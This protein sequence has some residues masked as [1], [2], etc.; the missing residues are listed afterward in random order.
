MKRNTMFL[1]WVGA[2]ISV[3]EIFTGGL[4]A[5]L[6][7]V[8]GSAAILVGHLIGTGLLALGAYV[9][10]VRGVNSM[11]NV[12]FAFGET[13]GRIVAAINLLQLL[14]WIVILI[15]QSGSAI[16]SVFPGI[17]FKVVTFTLSLLQIIWAM[18]FGTPASRINDLAVVLLALLCLLFFGEA[19]AGR[20][21]VAP[22]F[23]ASAMN[24]VLGIELSIAMPVSWLPLVGDYSSKAEDGAT[25]FIMPFLGYFA[26]SCF[27]YF[28][29]F[30]IALTGGRDIFS[31]IAASRF[32]YVA[33]C[34]VL[35]STI[36]T[37]FVALY[38]AAV[39][40]T[41][42]ICLSRF[43]RNILLVG[44]TTLLLAVL[45]PVERFAAILEHFLVSIDTV[46]V[47]IFT[48]VFLDF[49]RQKKAP[50]GKLNVRFVVISLIGM[51][52][53]LFFAKYVPFIPTV[54]TII[55]VALVYLIS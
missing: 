32:R 50:S 47:P 37:N 18:S 7:V 2:A 19:F 5:P 48:L 6:G 12:S 54:S 55:F 28:L 51:L 40:S 46:F 45:F 44:I 9:A 36:T 38:S 3:S 23:P 27:M 21:A 1:L 42:L 15:V 4:L 20:P 13:G 16:T 24:L 26:G 25:A 52:G 29:G 14:G 31:F 34:V 33:C 22:A 49:F 11:E 8:K 17:P 30:T 43:S 10:W 53:N 41:R 35:L 39:S